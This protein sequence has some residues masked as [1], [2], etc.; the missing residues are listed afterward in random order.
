MELEELICKLKTADYE[1]YKRLKMNP[2]PAVFI[3]ELLQK[4]ILVDSEIRIIRNQITQVDLE[5]VDKKGI[6]RQEEARIK[7]YR[8]YPLGVAT[9]NEHMKLV[10]DTVGK[11]GVV[12]NSM[13]TN[14]FLPKLGFVKQEDVSPGDLLAV[15]KESNLVFA[16]IPRDYDERIKSMEL[17]EKPQQSYEEIG[18][19]ER[20]IEELNEAIVLPLTHPERFKKLGLKPPKGVLL[21]GPPGTGKTLMARACA[22]KTNAT[23]LKLAGPQLVQMYIGEGAK[24]VRDA[25]ELAKEKAPSIIFI[26]EID[27]I[28]CKRSEGEDTEFREVQRTML[29]LLSRLDGFDSNDNIKFIAAT[30]R[31]DI[32]DPALM[33]SGR[34]DL[35][36]EFP[37]PNAEGRM[38][39]LQIHSR[40]LNHSDIDFEELARST[41]GFNGAQLKAVTVEAGMIALRRSAEKICH[42]DFLEGI[43]EVVSKKKSKQHYFT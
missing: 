8:I 40:K 36:I 34:I 30:N 4:K 29:E 37:L 3:Q 16:K 6:I 19:L 10:N 13:R 28:G 18:G 23:F 11:G 15:H 17:D 24:M 31:V 38:R 14:Y 12:C 42:N 41:D 27:A 22:A 25:F 1:L 21:Y 43:Q 35:K 2:D 32:L 39:V 20:Q 33:R 7:R 26:D 5:I 9:Y